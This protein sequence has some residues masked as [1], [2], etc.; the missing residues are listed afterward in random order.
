MATLQQIV[1]GGIDLHHITQTSGFR[2]TFNYI[3]ID[4]VY[5]IRNH[6]TGSIQLPK[7]KMLCFLRTGEHYTET[8]R[9][10]L[11]QIIFGGIGLDNLD[12][13]LYSD[14]YSD[15]D[16]EDRKRECLL[17]RIKNHTGE[18]FVFAEVL[19]GEE[20]CT[21]KSRHALHQIRRHIGLDL[22]LNLEDRKRENV[23]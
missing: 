9:Q 23:Y 6:C 8:K 19:R 17:R 5:C 2:D 16:L 21:E 12:L 3:K 4:T 14:L 7:E 20:H 1:L 22:D 15:F 10:W 18:N 11:Q 13:E